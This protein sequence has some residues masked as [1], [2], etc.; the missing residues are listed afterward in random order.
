[1]ENRMLKMQNDIMRMR[2][3]L[4]LLKDAE[5]ISRPKNRE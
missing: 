2:I 5:K 3:H 1:M 4:I